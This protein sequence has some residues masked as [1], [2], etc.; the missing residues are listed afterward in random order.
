MH[1][2]TRLLY[3]GQKNV[4]ILVTG[5]IPSTDS[6]LVKEF[7]AVEFSKLAGS[8]KGLRLDT[9][10][11]LI[12][13]KA[14]LQFWWAGEAFESF[15]LPMES[16]NHL[17]FDRPLDSPPGTTHVLIKP[18]KSESGPRMFMLLLDFSKQ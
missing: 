8:P 18:G 5:E 15:L 13:E 2:V 6:G 14:G 7:T 16:R 1:A 9:V 12:E 10:I 3:D 4:L 11:W 17:R